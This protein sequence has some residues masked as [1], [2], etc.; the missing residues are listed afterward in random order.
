MTFTVG[1]GEAGRADLV[2]GRRFPGASRNRLAALFREKRV[3][4]DGRVAKKGTQVP[5]GSQVTVDGEPV[6]DEDLRALPNPE[7]ELTVLYEDE[8]IVAIDKRAGMASHPLKAGELDTVANAVVARYPECATVGD[9]PRE[10]GLVHRLDRDTSGVLVVARAPETW[11]RLR[12]EL[13]AGR[14]EKRYLALVEGGPPGANSCFASLAQRGR[15]SVVDEGRGLD[16]HTEW[17]VVDRLDGYT[18]LECVAH[19]GR[20]HQIRAHLAHCGSPIAGDELYG[21]APREGITGHFLHAAR[22]SLAGYE[23]EAPLP[24]DRATAL[25]ALRTSAS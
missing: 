12:A 23:L 24:P 2:V 6:A 11:R 5:V 16:A 15:R 8:H 9:D 17:T 14:A 7:I 18:L 19:T 10:A 21:G 20:M 1:E 13:G 25:E 3:R 22:L 4:I